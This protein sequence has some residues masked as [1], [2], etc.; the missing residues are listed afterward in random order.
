MSGIGSS[1]ISK[2]FHCS[3]SQCKSPL[4]VPVDHMQRAASGSGSVSHS[5]GETSALICVVG[6]GTVALRPVCSNGMDSHFACW[7]RHGGRNGRL[8]IVVRDLGALLLG[9]CTF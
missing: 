7:C 3:Q 8:L 2:P 6:V 4:S 5:H 9:S 1:I